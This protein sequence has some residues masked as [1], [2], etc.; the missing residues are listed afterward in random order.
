MLER[1]RIAETKLVQ[2]IDN[3]DIDREVTEFR[4]DVVIIEAFWVVPEKFD[5]LMRLHPTVEWVVRVHS[6]VPFLAQEGIA[7]NWIFEYLKRDVSVAFNSLRTQLEF[8]QLTQSNDI[9]F[10]PNYFPRIETKE[11]KERDDIHI[12]CFGA[13]RPLKNQLIQAMAAIRYADLQ[14]KQL[15]FHINASRVEGGAEVLK[16]IRALFYQTG[17]NL[18]EH[19]WMNHEHFRETLAEMDISLCVSL[20][21]S[22]CLVAA[23]SVALGV[24][25]VASHAI[26]WLPDFSMADAT[27]MHSIVDSIFWVTRF[28]FFSKFMNKRKLRAYNDESVEIW[29]RFLIDAG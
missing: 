5:V 15:Y 7:I 1:K 17:H 9:F 19:E 11:K 2:V 21:E 4:P 13:I 12:G 6:E 16:N 27:N 28:K 29:K 14:G 20:S 22:F 25:L 26:R 23:E 8:L 24:P 10:L 18:V 3:N